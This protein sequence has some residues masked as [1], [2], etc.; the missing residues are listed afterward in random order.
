MLKIRTR[1]T[2]SSPNS[3]TW[4]TSSKAVNI[5]KS[6]VYRTH[7][8]VINA[9]MIQCALMTSGWRSTSNTFI[10]NNRHFRAKHTCTHRS[11]RGTV[12]DACEFQ[13]G[14]EIILTTKTTLSRKTRKVCNVFFQE[15]WSS[16]TLSFSKNN[17]LP[18]YFFI[19]LHEVECSSGVAW[20]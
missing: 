20:M 7:C 5:S 12:C 4:K 17:F 3:S 2:N 6:W 19:F 13:L 8:A 9:A 11:S 1:Y 16:W 14:A 15:F 10:L 18:F